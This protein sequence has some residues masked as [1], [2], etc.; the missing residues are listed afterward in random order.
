MER[1]GKTH[2]RKRSNRGTA[3]TKEIKRNGI[4]LESCTV[5]KNKIKNK[6]E[7]VSS[8]EH[9]YNAVYIMTLEKR[10]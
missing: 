3:S 6:R 8:E 9:V 5:L 2:E 10:I 4:Q 7:K 1:M